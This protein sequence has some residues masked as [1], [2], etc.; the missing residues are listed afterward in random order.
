VTEEPAS[1]GRFLAVLCSLA[2]AA[3]CCL[4][5][6]VVERL[7]S[8]LRD[9]AAPGHLGLAVA[10][11]TV[12]RHW[13]ARHE[14]QEQ[15]DAD[16][17]AEL[18]RQVAELTRQSLQ[19]QVRSATLATDLD[20]FHSDHPLPLQ[21][22]PTQP[23]LVTEALEARILSWEGGRAE[24]PGGAG[25]ESW[26][27]VLD[28]GRDRGVHSEEL[29][30]AANDPVVD[31][32]GDLRVEADQPV[33]AGQS[34]VGRIGVV[35]AWTSTIQPLTSPKFRGHAQLVRASADRAVEG[36]SGVLCGTG[37]GCRLEFVSPTEPVRVGDLVVTPLRQSPAGAP[38]IF[39]RV[40]RADLAPG[41]AHWEID[42]EPACN[43]EQT[44]RV[45]I[46]RVLVNSRR[47]AA[48]ADRGP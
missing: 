17:I 46:L 41:A 11:E 2:G 13:Q 1:P 15:A 42:V 45:S 39:G 35:G 8:G 23:L 7:R 40:T 26:R 44:S 18:Q 16:R 48:M 4:P 3:A 22:K 37:M 20:R 6:P 5:G 30:L 38:L 25:G 29:V 36:A 32:G 12:D 19:W 24:S 34:V 31:L 9:A 33:I 47:S 43:L 14:S 21:T 27:A 10:R 28:R